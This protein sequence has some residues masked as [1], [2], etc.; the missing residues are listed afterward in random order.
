VRITVFLF[1][2]Y[3]N[4]VKIETNH[5]INKNNRLKMSQIKECVKNTRVLDLHQFPDL[6]DFH[7]ENFYK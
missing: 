2:S 7:R 5:E 1:N 6:L 4:G 3:L